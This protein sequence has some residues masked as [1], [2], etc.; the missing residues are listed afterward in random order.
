MYNSV[1]KDP[2]TI[3]RTKSKTDAKTDKHNKI[4]T[5][6]LIKLSATT[7]RSFIFPLSLLMT[8]I[9]LL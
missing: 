8:F 4:R 9:E 2:L 6:I 5:I 7:M 1:S 3:R